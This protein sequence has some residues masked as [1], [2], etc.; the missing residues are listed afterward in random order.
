MRDRLLQTDKLVPWAGRIGLWYWGIGWC[1]RSW[2]ARLA[3]FAT[4]GGVTAIAEPCWVDVINRYPPTCVTLSLATIPSTAPLASPSSS[5]SSSSNT[6]IFLSL[7]DPTRLKS[8]ARSCLGRDCTL[9]RLVTA[10]C[11]LERKCLASYMLL[12]VP[13]RVVDGLVESV[14]SK[15]SMSHTTPTYR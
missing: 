7:S 9:R 15:L 8:S 5:S 2:V 6:S 3:L 11:K 4:H 1:G 10:I 14:P 13:V 12:H